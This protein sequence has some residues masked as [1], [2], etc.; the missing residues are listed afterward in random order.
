MQLKDAAKNWLLFTR[1][2]IA[3]SEQKTTG[4]NEHT[5]SIL[6]QGKVVSHHRNLEAS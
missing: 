6:V 2:N 1:A 5:T 3:D 4:Y